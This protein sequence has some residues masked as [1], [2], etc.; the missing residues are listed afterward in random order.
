MDRENVIKGLECCS[1]PQGRCGKCPYETE[2]SVAECTSELAKDAL[3]LL[4]EQEQMYYTLEHDWRMCRKLLKEQQE[5]IETLE[6]LRRIEQE[7]R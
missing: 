5:R 1:I 6:S 4:K 2:G 7:G 3:Y